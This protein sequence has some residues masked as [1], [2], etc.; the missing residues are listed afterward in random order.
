MLV[1]R[2]PAECPKGAERIP[3]EVDR[4]TLAKK[5]WRG[6]AADGHEFGFDLGHHL[7]NGDCVHIEEGKA[8]VIHQTPEAVFE[9]PLSEPQRAAWT[10]WMVGNLH[11]RAQFEGNVILVEADSAVRQMLEREKIPFAEGTRVFMPL[12]PAHTHD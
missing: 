5:R 9:I 12:A 1:I 10:G 7:H 2:Q 6:V 3:I 11:F 8:Y 4:H